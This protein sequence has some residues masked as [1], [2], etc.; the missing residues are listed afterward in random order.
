MWLLFAH[1]AIKTALTI[2]ENISSSSFWAVLF[3]WVVFKAVFVFKFMSLTLH[4]Q[5]H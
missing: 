3:P 1:S 4:I 2:Y 5:L